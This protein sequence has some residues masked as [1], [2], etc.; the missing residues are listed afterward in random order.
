MAS[1]KHNSLGRIRKRISEELHSTRE[2]AKVVSFPKAMSTFVG[3]I[4][5][6]L[7]VRSGEVETTHYKKHLLKKH[8]VMNQYF[9]KTIPVVPLVRNEELS[10]V[11]EALKGCVWVCWWQGLDNA[12]DIVKACVESIKAKVGNHRVIIITEENVDQ[13]VSF[14]KVMMDKYKAGIITRTHLSDYLRLELLSRYGGLWFDSTFFCTSNIEFV[15]NL[16]LWSIKRPDYLHISVASG[17]FANYSF[18]CDEEHR[19]IFATL[20]DYLLAYW[21]KYDYM[22]DYL[23]LDY[24]I[25]KAIQD[26]REIAKAF[27]EIPPNNPNCDELLKVLSKQYDVQKWNELIKD[28]NLF[29]LTWKKSFEKEV[30][31]Q[32]TFYGKIIS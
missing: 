8:K 28:T 23:F 31:G 18:A 27:S 6:Q 14:P 32:L 5:I 16:P 20:R 7:M 9:S 21:Q 19:W 24:L 29:K 11:N 2:I 1:S 3:K 15:F 26:Y 4:D 10:P 30:D 13:Y 17:Q 25:V 22:V 12:P